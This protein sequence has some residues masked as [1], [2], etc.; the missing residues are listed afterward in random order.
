M[1][2]DLN[3][4][5]CKFIYFISFFFLLTSILKLYQNKRFIA[6]QTFLIFITSQLYWR[7]GNRKSIERKIDVTVVS[8]IIIFNLIYYIYNKCNNIYVIIQLIIVCFYPLA[9][10]FN[11]INKM[12]IATYLHSLLHI[13]S[14]IAVLFFVN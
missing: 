11:Y 13:L 1:I 2:T 14:N 8:I 12:W 3:K 4:N 10:Y 6:L 5:Q 7:H 9:Q